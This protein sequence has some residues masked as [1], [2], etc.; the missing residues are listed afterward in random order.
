MPFCSSQ[1]H[2]LIIHIYMHLFTQDGWF[3]VCTCQSVHQTVISS[4][5]P[6]FPRT[7]TIY[8]T[9]PHPPPLPLFFHDE[10]GGGGILETPAPSAHLLF[11]FFVQIIYHLNHWTSLGHCVFFWGEGHILCIY[12]CHCCRFSPEQLLQS[13]KDLDKSLGLIVDL[14][15]TRKYYNPQV[16]CA[17]RWTGKIR[18]SLSFSLLIQGIEVNDICSKTLHHATANWHTI[19]VPL[20]QLILFKILSMHKRMIC[21]Y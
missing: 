19:L 2:L 9:H 13:I 5:S 12:D 8:I 7:W 16:I 3:L 15:F 1:L 20:P 14:T 6:Y 4:S 18:F 11:L 10:V 21:R 17:D